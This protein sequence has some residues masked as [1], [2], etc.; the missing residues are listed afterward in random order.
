[1]FIIGFISG[2]GTCAGLAIFLGLVLKGLSS[3]MEGY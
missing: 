3:D 1:M 2:V